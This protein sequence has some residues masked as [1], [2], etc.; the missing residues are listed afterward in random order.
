MGK[1]D[2]SEL[3]PPVTRKSSKADLWAEIEAM[4]DEIDGQQ[5]AL[6]EAMAARDAAI[7]EAQKLR[8]K[9]AGAHMRLN[10]VRAAVAQPDAA[11]RS[12]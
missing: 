12:S 3:P 4:Q 10:V 9:L 2:S 7:A 5:S 8:E 1:K 6:S 11:E